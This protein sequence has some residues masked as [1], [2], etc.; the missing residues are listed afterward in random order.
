MA[1]PFLVV[2]LG[3]PACGKSS[4][5]Q[6]LQQE[7]PGLCAVSGGDLARLATS[8]AAVRA[9][10][11]LRDIEKGLLLSKLNNGKKERRRNPQTDSRLHLREVVLSAMATVRGY[12]GVHG[13]LAD[14]LRTG[15][16]EPFEEKLGAS[17]VCV[18]LITC[19]R[20]LMVARYNSR[21]ARDG[22]E[23]LGTAGAD[24]RVSQY[25]KRGGEDPALHAH[26]G[27]SYNSVVHHV[28]SAGSRD[29]FFG[30][31]VA[32]LWKAAAAG[33]EK[34]LASLQ[35]AKSVKPVLIDWLA[36]LISAAEEP[37]SLLQGEPQAS[38]TQLSDGM[39]AGQGHSWRG[40]QDAS[41]PVAL[42]E[43]GR[44]LQPVVASV[45]EQVL[46]SSSR[47]LPAANPSQAYMPEHDFQSL[48]V[49]VPQHHCS[50]ADTLSWFGTQAWW[51]HSAVAPQWQQ[52]WQ[53]QQDWQATMPGTEAMQGYSG[54]TQWHTARHGL[55]Q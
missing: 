49:A 18:I 2:I 12:K 30:Q 35:M 17:V 15:D 46:P 33:G 9:S 6:H 13:L 8:D 34:A 43:H 1:Q 32:A 24:L 20:S 37:P 54:G 41:Q 36:A 55:Q 16:L 3:G 19:P 27:E 25:L 47:T 23:R 10:P 11:Q 50:A 5:A 29:V 22:D 38:S 48:Q 21:G 53:R 40:Y 26:F 45:V 4:L 28:S 14:S 39:V 42:A 31:A 52:T 44:D 51:S 7:F